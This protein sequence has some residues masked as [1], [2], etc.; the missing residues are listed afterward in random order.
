MYT[1]A[2]LFDYNY[3]CKIYYIFK[4]KSRYFVIIK[5]EKDAK[6]INSEIYAQNNIST[7]D[8][9][10]DINVSQDNKKEKRARGVIGVRLKRK[11]EL[12]TL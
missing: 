4:K 11:K 3:L 12:K 10:R 2:I 8:L 9:Q 6:D 5:K 1:S 7:L